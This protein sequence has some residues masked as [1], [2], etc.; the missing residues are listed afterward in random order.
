MIGRRRDVCGILGDRALFFE[1][2]LAAAVDEAD[3][4]VAVQ[5]QLP[6]G[7]G[8]EPIV[9]VAIEKNRCVIGNA[10]GAEKL[11]EGGLV[12]QV[13]A[14]VVLELGLPVPADGAGD[15]SLVVGGSVH[16]DFDEAEIGGIEI[17]RG[18][19]G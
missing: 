17:L 15:V 16:V 1:P 8:G 10:G 3:V 13:A 7:V 12:D 4:L 11:F 2:F 14:D 19:I 5:L 9:V 6:K 18:P